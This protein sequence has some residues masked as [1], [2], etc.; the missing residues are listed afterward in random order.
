MIYVR[1]VIN[2]SL[3]SSP[4]PIFI[5]N[6]LAARRRQWV[7]IR[8]MTFLIRWKTWVPR[9]VWKLSHFFNELMWSSAFKN[10]LYTLT[11]CHKK[12][13]ALL[14]I[15]EFCI[16]SFNKNKICAKKRQFYTTG[17]YE[18]SF[19]SWRYLNIIFACALN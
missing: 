1:I 4:F 9:Y 10:Q 3:S 18:L 14:R 19:F 7:L 12:V 15:Q 6:N 11:Q 17:F 5:N 16:P 13:Q 8:A 2:M